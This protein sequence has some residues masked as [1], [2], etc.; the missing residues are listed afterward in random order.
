[1]KIKY[2][3]PFILLIVFLLA[4]CSSTG[5]TKKPTKSSKSSEKKL[6]KLSVKVANNNDLRGYFGKDIVGLVDESKKTVSFSVTLPTGVTEV[7]ILP[8]LKS[9]KLTFEISAKAALKVG[10]VAQVSEKTANDFS[11]KTLTYTVVAEDGSKQNYTVNV[12]F[13]QHT[14]P[15]VPTT[16]KFT[17]NNA[18]SVS[19]TGQTQRLDMLSV[20]KNYLKNGDVGEV[21]K[22]DVLLNMYKNEN[23]PFARDDLN[24]AGKSI[25]SKVFAP[26]QDI[27]FYENWFKK[28][29]EASKLGNQKQQA[30]QGK[31]GIISRADASKTILVDKNGKEFTQIIEKGLMGSLILHQIFNVYLTDAKIGANVENTQL[32]AGKNYTTAEHHWDEAFGYFGVPIDFPKTT[33]KTFWG[34]YTNSRDGLLKVN[35]TIMGAF[36]KGRAAIVAKN[37]SEINAQRE[38]VYQTLE[39]VAAATAI[40]Y[41]NDTKKAFG[42]SQGEVFHLLSEAYAFVRALQFSPKKKITQAQIDEILNTDFGENFWNITLAGLDKAKATLVKVYPVLDAVKDGL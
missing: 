3:S 8:L 37:R 36:I 16:Y 12:E 9:I 2:I 35:A 39:L 22:E 26:D 38:I 15:Q 23:N 1:M 13:K 19:Y 42:Q 11:K 6:L 25:A 29:A 10:N 20:I 34:N 24:K 14:A 30:S 32:V 28:A 27:K 40:H 18:S 17:R 33:V 41:I 31:A 5:D 21:I 7:L 4:S